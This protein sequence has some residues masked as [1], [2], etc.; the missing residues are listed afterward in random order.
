M[1]GPRPEAID[2]RLALR[3]YGWL[4]ISA[5]LFV[6]AWGPLWLRGPDVIP[7]PWADA[8]L[9]RTSAAAVAA[10]GCCAVIFAASD[11]PRANRI[12]LFGVAA[13]HLLFGA[14][15]YVQWSAVLEPLVPRSIALAPMAVG[16]VLLYLALTGPNADVPGSSGLTSLFTGL[17]QTQESLRSRY[18]E[19]IRRAAR[20]EERARLA[21]DL[22]DAVKQQLFV[23]QTAAATAQVRLD[24]DPAAVRSALDEVRTA[25]RN[26]MSEMQAMLEQLQ[27]APLGNAGLA[28]AI[29]A[30]LDAVAARTGA[31]GRLDI[32]ALP[33]DDTL[34]PGAREAIFRVAQEALANIARHA[35]AR[36]VQVSLELVGTDLV[37]L[38][39]DDGLGFDPATASR[40]MGLAN[41]QARADEAEADLT[42]RSEAGGGT[43]I[44]LSLPYDPATP[45]EHAWKA[46]MWAATVLLSSVVLV[47]RR[48]LQTLADDPLLAAILAI[49]VIAVARH[50][51][52][53]YCLHPRRTRA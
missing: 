37:L 25:A 27:A 43:T 24:T 33:P 4:A 51:Y 7:L 31:S 34:D 53:M 15:F 29:R 2:S 10:A 50:A 23:V 3:V 48:G 13:A 5:G 49:G 39:S 6:V 16:L 1:R 22:H 45:H 26:A 18:E 30:Q 19:Q 36:N 28:E 8:A 14:V 40:G 12:G 32:G 52:A 9:L 20:H 47:W 44:R 46:A 41:M 35:R 17:R 11:D 42:L 21:R 38:V